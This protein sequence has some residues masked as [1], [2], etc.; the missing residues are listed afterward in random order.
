M[1]SNEKDSWPK[2]RGDPSVLTSTSF[3]NFNWNCTALTQCNP[4]S[5]I[6]WGGSYETDTS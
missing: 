5:A 6:C 4:G 3:S 2:Q 1:L